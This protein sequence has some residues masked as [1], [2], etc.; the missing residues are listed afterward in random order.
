M[1]AKA[2]EEELQEIRTKSADALFEGTMKQFHPSAERVNELIGS[3]FE[4]GCYYLVSRQENKLAGWVLI[5]PSADFF[6]KEEIGFIYE[7]YVVPEYRGQGLA[8][9]LMQKA[10]DELSIKGYRE[11][12]LSVHAGNFAQHVYRE[13]GFVDKQISMSFQVV[14]RP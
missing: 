3:A 12:R 2:T 6:S 11:I 8:K 5:G 10:I 14:K 4:K 1:I 9:L 7:L 13:L